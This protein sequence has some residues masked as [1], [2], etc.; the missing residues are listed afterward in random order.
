MPT[1]PSLDLGARP[2]DSPATCAY[3]FDL[4]WIY[5]ARRAVPHLAAFF[6]SITLVENLERLISSVRLLLCACVPAYSVIPDAVA[7]VLLR[8]PPTTD[9]WG[10]P[11]PLV[12]NEMQKWPV[13]L[14]QMEI[15]QVSA[16]IMQLKHIL[17]SR[18]V[19]GRPFE[20]TDVIEV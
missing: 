15:R 11:R 7:T 20:F 5:P 4:F 16:L 12:E 3:V 14:Q 2:T 6:F 8:R 10:D 19:D 18:T 17:L 1:L 13:P 9:A